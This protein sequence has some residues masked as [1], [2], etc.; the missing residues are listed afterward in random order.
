MFTVIGRVINEPV[1]LTCAINFSL[2][3]RFESRA[4]KSKTAFTEDRW[5]EKGTLKL[6]SCF[7][8]A[9]K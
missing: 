3:F 8:F 2:L 6:Q 5:K 9:S 1:E 7:Q 4:Q